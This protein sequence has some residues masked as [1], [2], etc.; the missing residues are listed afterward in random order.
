MKTVVLVYCY[1]LVYG[2]KVI[3]IVIVSSKMQKKDT[4]YSQRANKE[5]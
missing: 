2:F 5:Y 3:L 4:L 1:K